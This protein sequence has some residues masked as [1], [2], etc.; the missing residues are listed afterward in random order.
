MDVDTVLPAQVSGFGEVGEG[1]QG[2]AERH[3]AAFFPLGGKHN[4]AYENVPDWVILSS[5]NRC[6]VDSLTGYYGNLWPA[7]MAPLA[8]RVSMVTKLVVQSLLREVDRDSLIALAAQCVSLKEVHLPCFEVY[9]TAFCFLEN[10]PETLSNVTVKFQSMA[11]INRRMPEF[12]SKRRKPNNSVTRVFI[13]DDD[14]SNLVDILFYFFPY[15]SAWPY[16][17]LLRHYPN[18]KSLGYG[19]RESL[20]TMSL[21]E[22][23]SLCFF[24]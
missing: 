10:L 7:I 2:V 12:T 19:E 17:Q 4:Y 9:G 24:P 15:W 22:V 13:D 8:P 18:L 23:T 3:H 5:L 1:V 11:A 16:Q 20:H 14:S 21:F 6:L